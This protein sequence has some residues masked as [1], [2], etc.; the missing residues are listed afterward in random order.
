MFLQ[1]LGTNGK[2]A[3]KCI[4]WRVNFRHDTHK[5]PN[6]NEKL[7]N[8]SK[9]SSTEEEWYPDQPRGIKEISNAHLESQISKLTKVVLLLTKEKGIEPK[10]KPCGICCKTGQP[11]DRYPLLQEDIEFVQA[12]VGLQQRP[13]DQHRNNQA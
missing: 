13:F 12:M 3:Y 2:S 5:D 1:R 10:F 7:A 11:T 9:H 8:E 4:K 6:I